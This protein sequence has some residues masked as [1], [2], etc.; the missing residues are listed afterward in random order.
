MKKLYYTLLLALPML[1]LASCDDDNNLPDVDVSI[2]IDG[3][4][5]VD[6]A[7]YV[8]QGDTLKIEG[9]NVINNE[10]GK[11]AV[12]TSA[13][14]SWDYLLAG[15]S[16]TPPYGASFVTDDMAIGQ[17]LLQ[18][19]CPLYAVDKSPALMYMAYKVAIVETADD[20]PDGVATTVVSVDPGI[21][22]N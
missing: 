2:Q 14:Y 9:I 3:G 8:V 4:V 10:E 21:K 17:H 15:V 13:T 16:L 6:G 11:E 19:E 12:I 18:I 22:E 5:G 1:Y 20:I 7:I